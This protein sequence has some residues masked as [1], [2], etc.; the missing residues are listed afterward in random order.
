MA[1]RTGPRT[2]RDSMRALRRQ[3]RCVVDEPMKCS[4]C[5]RRHESDAHPCDT[6]AI[7]PGSRFTARLP[8]RAQRLA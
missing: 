1:E 2:E 6:S 8:R 5:T 3:T 4:A 7:L